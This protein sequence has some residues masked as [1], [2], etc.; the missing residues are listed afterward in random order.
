M[1][2]TA[3]HRYVDPQFMRVDNLDYYVSGM[4]RLR[5]RMVI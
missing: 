3:H 2:F 1:G 4:Y 5:T